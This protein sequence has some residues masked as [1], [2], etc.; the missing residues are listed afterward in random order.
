MTDGEIL[1]EMFD[2]RG[3]G[4]C[5]RRLPPQCIDQRHTRNVIKN[6]AKVRKVSQPVRESHRSSPYNQAA[7][8]L[9]RFGW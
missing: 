4:A 5:S 6:C 9:R 2:V 3:R 8:A 1:D 7:I